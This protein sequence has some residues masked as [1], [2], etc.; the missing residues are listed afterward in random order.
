MN[1]G[2]SDVTEM[3]KGVKQGCALATLFI[4]S[5]EFPL[6]VIQLDLKDVGVSFTAILTKMKSPTSN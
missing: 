5:F 3:E 1:G 2:N 6:V 4:V